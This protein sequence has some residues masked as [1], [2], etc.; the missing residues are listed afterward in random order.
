MRK[1]EVAVFQFSELSDTAKERA[2]SDHMTH[3]GYS[4]GDEAMD[5]IKALAKHFGG[6]MA[7][8]S[9]D[10]GNSTYSS[11]TFE[12]PDDWT[13]DEI[14]PLL[15][16]LGSFDPETLKGLGD[17]KL[18]GYCMD[19][20]AIDGFRIAYLKDG[21]RNLEK[22][23]DAAFDSWLEDAHADFEYQYSDEAFAENCEANG[24]EFYEDG[25]LA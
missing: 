14:K 1:I 19:E 4:W 15:D 22:L 12:M 6:K 2:K 9:I 17:C 16:E 3:C 11:A 8:W 20:S 18:T 13:E 24:Y 5:S 10:W 23:M 25:E 21:E 7:K